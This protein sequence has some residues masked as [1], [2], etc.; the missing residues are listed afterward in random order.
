MTKCLGFAAVAQ[1]GSVKEKGG[2]QRSLNREYK[3]KVGTYSGAQTVVGEKDLIK[4]YG[5]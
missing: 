5:G 3:G 4:M 2:R 1:Q